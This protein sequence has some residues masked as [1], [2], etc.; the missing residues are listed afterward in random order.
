MKQSLQIL[1]SESLAKYTTFK[2]G[3]PADYF[4][5]VKSEE[6]LIEAVKEANRLKIPCFFLGGGSN[7]LISGKGYRGMV[8]KN[9]MNQI[10]M[11]GYRGKITGRQNTAKTV[12]LKVDAGVLV[13]R[14]VRYSLDQGLSGLENFLGQPGTVGGAVYINAHNMKKNDFFGNY[15]VEAKIMNRQG[16][17]RVEKQEYFK[18]GYDKSIIQKTKEMV[19]WVIIRFEKTDD[20]DKLWIKANNAMAHRQKTQPYGV[21]SSGCVFQNIKKSD[22]LRIGTP[23]HT[24]ST[25]FLI[26]A[27][28][29][30]GRKIG[31]AKFSE[32]H[33]NFI[34]AD[35]NAKAQD[36]LELMHLA[37]EKARE[38]FGVELEEEIILV[39]D[40]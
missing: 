16:S 7:V 10:Q 24:C 33:A 35:M 2:I 19:I 15:L 5:R 4:V 6:E 26:D 27:S 17:A 22:A 34:V 36:V 37:K 18:F 40:F 3:G 39:G 14:L 28:G 1:R 11:A 38:K 29:L 12:H 31:G 30:K 25:G 13:N 9:E 8:I 32:K 23:D 20:K 21:A